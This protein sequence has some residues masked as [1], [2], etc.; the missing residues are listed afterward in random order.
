[1]EETLL[2]ETVT[3][4]VTEQ[5]C[6]CCKSPNILQGYP[7]RLCAQCRE[8][9]IKYPIPSWIKAFGAAIAILVVFS[10]INVYKNLIVGIH[11]E[12]GV[13]A[14]NEK[15]YLTAQKEFEKVVT[16]LPGNP[17]A[18]AHLLIGAFYNSDFATF[19][20]CAQLLEGKTFEDQELFQ[21]AEQYFH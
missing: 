18:R 2:P 17:E 7:N 14:E 12:R 21:K 10:S 6:I 11:Y 13:K 20:K 16:K 5:T 9:Y 1:M 19:A 15:R 4:E 3:A 8:S